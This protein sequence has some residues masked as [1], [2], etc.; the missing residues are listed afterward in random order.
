MAA[1]SNI[2]VIYA[3]LQAKL[4]IIVTKPVS[5]QSSVNRLPK[6]NEPP[7]LPPMNLPHRIPGGHTLDWWNKKNAPT[8][9]QRKAYSMRT[10]SPSQMGNPLTLASLQQPHPL[11]E[12]ISSYFF[13]GPKLKL[14]CANSFPDR[15]SSLLQQHAA[16][17]PPFQRTLGQNPAIQN[18]DTNLCQYTNQTHRS[19]YPSS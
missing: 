6:I 4:A 1:G 14:Q 19:S 2:P 5:L 18:C 15:F 8:S 11:T 9:F 10:V 16:I 7:D 3:Q 13:E 12:A 17:L